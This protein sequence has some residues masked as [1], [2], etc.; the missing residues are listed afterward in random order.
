[1]ID[2][3][4]KLAPSTN[5]RTMPPD[6]RKRALFQKQKDLLDTFLSHG[7]I[8]R[9]QYEKSLTCMSEKMGMELKQTHNEEADSP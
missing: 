2:L 4:L 5:W 9:R 7:A 1:M 6:E 8:D 3:D